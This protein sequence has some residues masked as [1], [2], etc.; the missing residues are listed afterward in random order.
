MG[1]SEPVIL[2]DV[3]GLR[4][5]G[6]RPAEVARSADLG[7]RLL[8]RPFADHETVIVKPSNVINSLAELL[9][10]LAPEAR[11]VF[12]YAPLET[13]LIS[14]ARKGLPCRLWVRELMA[15]YLPEG[16]IAP[17]GMEPEDLFRQSDLQVAAVGWLAQ[18]RLFGKLAQRLGPGRLRTLDSETL[19]SRP[20]STIAAAA[21]HYSIALDAPSVAR[22][23]AGPAFTRHSK[24]GAAFTPNQR[25][26]EYAAARSIHGE[27][28]D[29]VCT[30]AMN[31]AE[32][33]GIAMDAPNALV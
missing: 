17:L 18:H 26:A 3:V 20:V 11:A 21:E 29:L 4:R 16:M 2:N 6:A 10:A 31:I 30:W 32:Q 23:A 19:T 1:L 14:V 25:S 7:L 8:A 12:L 24:S 28:I 22:I 5:R 9:L 33:A 13:F 15:G 27:E